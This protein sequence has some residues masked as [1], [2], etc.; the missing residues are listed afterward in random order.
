M[1]MHTLRKPIQP[2]G[3]QLGLKALLSSTAMQWVTKA[4]LPVI[5]PTVRDGLCYAVRPAIMD[6]G[7]LWSRLNKKRWVRNMEKKETL[8]A[9]EERI[10]AL[11]EEVRRLR[12][13]NARLCIALACLIALV[14]VSYLIV[15]KEL[16][17]LRVLRVEKLEFV[18]DG[19][20]VASV[21]GVGR[22]NIGYAFTIYD[23]DNKPMMEIASFS[24][25]SNS[26]LREVNFYNENAKPGIKFRVSPDGS[27]T[28]VIMN[29]KGNVVAALGVQDTK[30]PVADPDSGYLIIFNG[31]TQTPVVSLGCSKLG[32][33]LALL[34]NPY[35]GDTTKPAVG[36]GIT[37]TGSGSI[38]T[39]KRS[40]SQIWG[41]PAW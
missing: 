26:S 10:E 6:L 32:G 36:I 17:L 35:V 9:I 29:R 4:S 37:T 40:G 24:F 31:V 34:R 8:D 14:V 21:S 13:I 25:A 33:S 15:G 2:L 12:G 38:V 20:L 7:L 3:A 18:K 23:G 27:G 22:P 41:T 30:D 19:E 16:K 28:I 5:Q 39:T 1:H 11:E